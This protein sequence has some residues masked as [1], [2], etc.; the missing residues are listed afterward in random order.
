MPE[1]TQEMIDNQQVWVWLWD[2]IVTLD[3]ALEAF[4]KGLT[5]DR[6]GGHWEVR[7]LGLVFEDEGPDCD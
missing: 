7:G 5:T 1:L 3:E 4:E 2:D 6:A